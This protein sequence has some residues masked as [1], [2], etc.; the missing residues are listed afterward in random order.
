MCMCPGG[1]EVTVWFLWLTFCRDPAGWSEDTM[2]ALVP[3]LLLDDA[4][5]S[6]LPNKV[7]RRFLTSSTSFLLS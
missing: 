1:E 6:S 7:R 2:E 3:L 5:V 4:A